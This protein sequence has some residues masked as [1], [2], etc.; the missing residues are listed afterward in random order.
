MEESLFS[1]CGASSE[2]EP[3]LK[4]AKTE[5]GVFE[6]ATIGLTIKHGRSS[7]PLP[8]MPTSTIAELKQQLEELTEVPRGM[9]KLMFKGV[10]QDDSQV[11]E[12]KL[13]DGSKVMMLG[14]KQAV[15]EQ[16]LVRPPDSEIG[17]VFDDFDLDYVPTMEDFESNSANQV[18]KPFTL[19]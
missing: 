16:A 1:A 8:V 2:P 3:A 11:S 12:T 15:V 5:G 14:N 10:L 18:A 7:Y 6:S 19:F 9:I 13:K 4:S 17:E